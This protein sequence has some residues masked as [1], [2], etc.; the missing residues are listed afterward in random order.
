M[1]LFFYTVGVHSSCIRNNFVHEPFFLRTYK[2]VHKERIFHSLNFIII[3][4][5]N[6]DEMMHKE[7]KR[8]TTTSFAS[9]SEWRSRSY[10]ESTQEADEA[11]NYHQTRRI[12][13][14]SNLASYAWFYTHTS[15]HVDVSFYFPLIYL[16]L[17][18]TNL[19]TNFVNASKSVPCHKLQRI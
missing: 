16:H 8:E 7:K 18:T 10:S 4:C 11:A 2:R 6:I 13:H 5:K 1:A 3:L 17:F 19:H 9:L 15:L 12:T 14:S